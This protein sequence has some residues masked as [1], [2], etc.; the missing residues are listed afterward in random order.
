[1]KK[2]ILINVLITLDDALSTGVSAYQRC[3]FHLPH[4][5]I[6]YPQRSAT[7][8]EHPQ[9]AGQTAQKLLQE[10]EHCHRKLFDHG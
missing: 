2:H 3:T 4:P 9:P 8:C 5:C 1:M 10:E 6:V 7:C